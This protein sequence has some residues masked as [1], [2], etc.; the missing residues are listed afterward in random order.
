M[1]TMANSEEPDKNVTECTISSR[2]VLSAKLEHSSGAPVM[3]LYFN[4]PSQVH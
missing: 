3:P 2:S 1:G 4:E